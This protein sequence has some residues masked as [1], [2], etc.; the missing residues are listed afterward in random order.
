MNFSKILSLI[1]IF[2]FSILFFN[3]KKS[4]NDKETILKGTATILVD[5][6][7]KPIIE[8]QIA[9][10]EGQ[11]KASVLLKS[12]SE[13]EVMLA[14]LKDTSQIAI[15]SRKLT[16]E[17]TKHFEQNKINPKVT[18]IGSDAIAFIANKSN[19]DTLVVLKDVILF[20]QGKPQSTIKGLVFDNPNS[21]TVRYM[22]ELAG[23]SEMPKN[24]IYSFKVN[25]DVIKFVAKNDGI[26]GVIGLN[27]LYQPSPQ[28][29]ALVNDINVMSVKGVD[30]NK[31]FAP[32]QNNLAEGKY[33]LARDLFI[34]NCQGYSGLGMG[35]ASFVAG[36]IGQRIIL[37]SGLLP[38]RTPG[39]KLT[40]KT[41]SKND[42]N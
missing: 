15:L 9:V 31:F 12:R 40:I 28:N 14:F 13:K 1:L 26:I 36:D 8:D 7:I 23:I 35:F 27:W 11:Y 10:F 42:E 33:P 32:T 17:E 16:S 39:R 30:S 25:E 3:C 5:E 18:K 29:A 20:M 22:S 6:T 41:N 37:K 21:S 24:G 2:C 19:K 34:I 4:E 38:I